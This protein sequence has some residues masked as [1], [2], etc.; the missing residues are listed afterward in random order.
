MEPRSGSASRYRAVWSY[1]LSNTRLERI[2][3]TSN[4]S[5]ILLIF[6]KSFSEHSKN[7]RCEIP[8]NMRIYCFIFSVQ[9][10]EILNNRQ[11]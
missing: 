9:I 6:P 7:I 8:G 10:A 11:K 3:L 1:V 2:F 5:N 4:A